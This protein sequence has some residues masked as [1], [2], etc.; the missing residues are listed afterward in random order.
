MNG[1]DACWSCDTRRRRGPEF[2][3]KIHRRRRR[4]P[5]AS[6]CC[7]GILSLPSPSR[8]SRWAGWD[9]KSPPPSGRR[10]QPRPPQLWAL[11][12]P[13]R[14]QKDLLDL[15]EKNNKKNQRKSSSYSPMYLSSW[16]LSPP[17]TTLPLDLFRRSTSRLQWRDET[18]R[19]KSGLLWGSVV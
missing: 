13:R 1:V 3:P 15:E 18:M 8:R 11:R 14:Q 19:Q 10:R 7:S 4:A 2:L 17:T 16:S 5:E 6:P 9:R 12:R